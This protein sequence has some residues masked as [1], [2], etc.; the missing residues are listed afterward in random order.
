MTH[1]SQARF[2]TTRWDL[3]FAAADTSNAS[4]REDF[5]RLYWPPLYAFARRHGLQSADA[6]DVVQTYLSRFI[7]NGVLVDLKQEGG[8]LRDFLRQGLRNELIDDYRARRAARRSPINGFVSLDTG[9]AEACIAQKS[10][11]DLAPDAEYDARCA[12]ALLDAARA[13]LK[14]EYV[15]AGKAELFD[16]LVATLDGIDRQD[17]HTVAAARLGFTVQTLKNKGTALRRRFRELFH[18]L[19]AATLSSPTSQRIEEE[20]AALRAALRTAQT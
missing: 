5:V 17:N 1:D 2:L 11:N 9:A 3:V 18:Q 13:Q 6:A 7:Q 14:R 10:M 16:H 12:L 19:V 15:A 4:L 8:R 20:V